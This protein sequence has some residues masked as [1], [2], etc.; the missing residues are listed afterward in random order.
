MQYMLAGGPTVPDAA[1]LRGKRTAVSRLGSSSHLSTKFILKHLGLDPE[2]DVTYVQVGNTPDRVAALL[3]GSVDAT[4]LSMDEG[5]LLRN[6]P[7]MRILVDMTREAVPYCANAVVTTRSYARENPD[8]LRRFTRAYVEMTARY[9][10]SREQGMAAVSHHLD[11]TD[12]QRVASI[13]E[14]WVSLFVD[15]PYP[16]PQAV[17]FVLDEYAQSD[18]RAREFQVDDLIDRSWLRA[19]DDTGYVDSLYRAGG[20]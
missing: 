12:P 3:T 11:E 1:S 19:L 9:K 15:K 5:T 14:S 8:V 10:L 6:Q 17:Q 7:D 16:D 13:Y 18:P 20:R 4:I 2:Q